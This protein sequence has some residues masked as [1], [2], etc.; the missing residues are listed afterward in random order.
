MAEESKSKKPLDNGRR[1]F[2]NTA[3]IAGIAGAGVTLGLTGCNKADNASPC[4]R[5]MVWT[6]GKLIELK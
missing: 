6:S 3:G 5:E 1:K 4:E 2:L